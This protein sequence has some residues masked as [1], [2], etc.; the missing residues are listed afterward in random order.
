MANAMQEPRPAGSPRGGTQ[1]NTQSSPS[2]RQSGPYLEGVDRGVLR[3]Q[4]CQSCGAAQTLS[5]Y[6]CHACDGERFD[7]LDSHGTG[8]VHSLTVVNRAQS[9][10]FRSLLPYTLVLVDLDEGARV[11]AHAQ[12]GLG[13]GDRVRATGFSHEGLALIRFVLQ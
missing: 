2:N 9:E 1:S 4:R 3:F 8:I 12:A 5:R 7:W 10:A 6:S 13:I 11:M